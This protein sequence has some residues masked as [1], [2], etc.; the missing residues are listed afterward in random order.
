MG[1]MLRRGE[2]SWLCEKFEFAFIDG[3]GILIRALRLLFWSN[4]YVTS[5]FNLHVLR[6]RFANGMFMLFCDPL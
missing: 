6:M 2:S 4:L 5:C 3:Y 1:N